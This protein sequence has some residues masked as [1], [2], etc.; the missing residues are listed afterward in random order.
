MNKYYI[1]F[2]KN[3]GQPGR[4][5][6]EHVWRVFENGNEILAKHVLIN[7]PVW[8]EQTGQDYNMACVG[9]MKFSKE[10]DTVEI[11]HIQ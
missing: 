9:Y 1:R 8:S 4:G 5:S 11:N 7:A 10:F 6:L 3:A 2:N